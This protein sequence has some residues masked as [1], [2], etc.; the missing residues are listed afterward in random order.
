MGRGGLFIIAGLLL[1]VGAGALTMAAITPWHSD[2]DAYF[3][4][5]GVIRENLYSGEL[6]F[7]AASN[8]FHDL[9]DR[10]RTA[11]WLWAD[12]G[13]AAIA[14][15]VL[16]GLVAARRSGRRAPL[17]SRS[18]LLV[19]GTLIAGLGLL[20]VGLL[21]GALQPMARQQV[22]EWADSVAI[23]IMGATFSIVLLA[24]VYLLST[25]T[26]LF[27]RQTPAALFTTGVGWLGGV[28]ISLIYLLPVGL[29]FFMIL[30]LVGGAGGWAVSSA[31]WLLGWAALN[32]RAIALG[33]PRASLLP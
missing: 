11:K 2:S 29:A 5:L 17:T 16:A 20:Y 7:E 15:G 23:P 27:F 14:W 24:P 19:T 30:M 32:G 3:A 13:Y 18:W 1:A 12:Y 26:P 25:L 31:G 6:D 10:Y 22:P 28:V 8:R 21:A 33:A 9:Q 4:G